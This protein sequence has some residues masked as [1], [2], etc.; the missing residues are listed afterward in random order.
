MGIDVIFKIRP[1]K[2]LTPDEYEV[3]RR[4]F[5]DA[6]P[7]PNAGRNGYRCPELEWDDFESEPTIE[8]SSLDR[9]YGVDYERGPWP[10]I[11][12]LGDWLVGHIEGEL[13]YGGDHADEWEF[14]RPWP[15][16]RELLDQHWE[17]C[18]NEPYRRQV[19]E[20]D[21]GRADQ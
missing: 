13:R 15:Q 8:V 2:S 17:Q 3:L 18:G 7:D 5:Y 6:H 21:R 10:Q 4:K 9:Y 1:S 20:W 16:A 19:R 14:L 11:K 12:A